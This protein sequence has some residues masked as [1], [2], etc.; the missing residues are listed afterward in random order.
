MIIIAVHL[1]YSGDLGYLEL[2][3]IWDVIKSDWLIVI[4]IAVCSMV[5]PIIHVETKVLCTLQLYSVFQK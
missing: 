4:Y 2:W 3:D 5:L 1:I